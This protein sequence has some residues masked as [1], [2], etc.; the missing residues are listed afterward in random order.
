M[1]STAERVQK[2][3]ANLR[4]S[5]LRPLQ[6]WVPDTKRKGFTEKCKRQSLLNGDV[7]PISP[8]QSCPGLM[9]GF[10]NTIF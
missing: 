3:R 1:A 8:G 10:E 2:H 4:A 7:M 9:G 5:G 6:I